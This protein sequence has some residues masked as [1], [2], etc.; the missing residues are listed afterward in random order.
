M[1]SAPGPEP[2]PL[3]SC[4]AVTETLHPRRRGEA[5][6]LSESQRTALEASETRGNSALS[7]LSRWGGASVTNRL[8]AG[9]RRG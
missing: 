6:G 4:R 2:G 9:H 7:K 1:W 8:G 5:P 3:C